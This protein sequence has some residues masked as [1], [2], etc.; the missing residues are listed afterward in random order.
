[1]KRITAFILGIWA[2]V[3][4]LSAEAALQLPSYASG[5]SNLQGDLES[6]GGAITKILLGVTVMI[7]IAG[8]VFSGMAFASG[9]GEK[10]K[11]R[12]KYSVIGLIVAATATGIASIATGNH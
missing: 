2:F 10:G 5:G 7:G 6:T 4:A 9:D 11:E 3:Y 12:L 8:I 1:M